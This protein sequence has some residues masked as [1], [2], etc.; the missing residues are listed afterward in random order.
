MN[1][2]GLRCLVLF[3]ILSWGG[4]AVLR[5]AVKHRTGER[6][7]TERDFSHKL[8]ERSSNMGSCLRFAINWTSHFL[9]LKYKTKW[10]L[11]AT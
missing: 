10:A 11:W 3:S 9:G 5:K 1:V 7:G 6:K 2:R 8:L 4:W